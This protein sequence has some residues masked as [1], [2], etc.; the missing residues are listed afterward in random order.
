MRISDWSSDVCPSDLP[1]KGRPID[2]IARDPAAIKLGQS[3]F[4]NN[5]ATCHGSSA[6]GA[7]GFPNLSDDIWHWGGAPEDILTSIL[8]GREGVM[9]EWG[10]EIGRASCRE[11]VCQYVSLSVV[12]VT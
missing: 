8:D 11:R 1:Y 2:E 7:I 5:C 12:A 6:Q 10:T 3:I 9:P 4:S